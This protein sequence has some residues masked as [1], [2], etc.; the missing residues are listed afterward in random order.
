[1]TLI[2]LLKTIAALVPAYMVFAGSLLLYF[3]NKNPSRLLQLLGAGCLVIVVLSHL[4]EALH[5]FPI[6]HWGEGHSVGHY[7][8]LSS[9]VLGVSFF[10]LGYFLHALPKRRP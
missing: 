4:S 10:C 7:L 3:R 6:M 9:A 1:V 2:A 8:D 5:L